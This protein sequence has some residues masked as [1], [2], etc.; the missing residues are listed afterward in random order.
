MQVI[1]QGTELVTFT[2]NTGR[3]GQPDRRTAFDPWLVIEVKA[4]ENGTAVK[5]L[6]FAGASQGPYTV[7]VTEGFDEVKQMIE[8]ARV[9]TIAQRAA[10]LQEEAKLA[11]IT[12][13]IGDYVLQKLEARLDG[14]IEAACERLL[15][16]EVEAEPA[17]KKK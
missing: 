17:K 8:A 14:K 2:S 13:G 15:A 9:K 1:F 11:A 3:D 7:Y 5:L 12:Q 16:K 6:H 4:N 10:A